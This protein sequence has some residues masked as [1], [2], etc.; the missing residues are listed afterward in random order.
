M[1]PF[2][3]CPI[4]VLIFN[5]SSGSDA[6]KQKPVKVAKSTTVE[7]TKKEIKKTESQ[8][9]TTAKEKP[10]TVKVTQKVSTGCGP[11][12]PR[13]TPDIDEDKDIHPEEEVDMEIE[14][15]I[16]EDFIKP[17]PIKVSTSVGTSPPPQSAS[18]QVNS[19]HNLPC[20]FILISLISPRPTTTYHRRRNHH[21]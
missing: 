4:L 16:Q 10:P 18:T 14:E 2:F 19:F 8:S 17:E 15:I 1:F 7:A 12:P 20:E 21:Q 11:S 3:S 13:D 9:Q 6:K 5:V